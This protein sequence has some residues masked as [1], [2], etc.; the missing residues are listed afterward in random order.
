MEIAWCV[1]VM[2]LHE[3]RHLP[4][5]A[6]RFTDIIPIRASVTYSIGVPAWLVGG[7]STRSATEQ[8]GF[9]ADAHVPQ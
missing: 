2:A 6:E 3:D 7:A 5:H 1:A 9:I 8:E 4:V